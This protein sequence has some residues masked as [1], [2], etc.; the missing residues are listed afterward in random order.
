MI[1]RAGPTVGLA[2]EVVGREVAS[3]AVSPCGH[4]WCTTNTT[5]VLTGPVTKIS[6]QRASS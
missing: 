3:L 2:A 1:G 4:T 6:V 5:D